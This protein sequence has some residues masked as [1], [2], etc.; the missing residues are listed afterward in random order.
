MR[1]TLRAWVWVAVTV[2]G[3]G[4]ALLAVEALVR[5]RGAHD[6]AALVAAGL[7]WCGMALGAGAAVLTA[8]GRRG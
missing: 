1:E 3:A 4:V 2:C 5:A 8:G 6:G 7:G